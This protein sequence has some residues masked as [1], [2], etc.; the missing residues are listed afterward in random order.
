MKSE[1][2]H[3]VSLLSAPFS[4]RSMV[5]EYG[6][7]AYCL[8]PSA[9]IFVN[10]N[11]QNLYLINQCSSAA[12]KKIT[13]TSTRRFGDL[14]WD[15][16][17][18]RV[19]AVCEDHSSNGDVVN[20]IVA[21]NLTGQVETLA[22]GCDFYAYPRLSDENDSLCWI[23][24]MQPNMPWDDTQLTVAR[25][26]KDGALTGKSRLDLAEAQSIVQP[27]WHDD[28]IY[29]V[30]DVGNW[31]NI[32]RQIDGE[33]TNNAVDS[34]QSF[35]GPQPLYSMKAEF[36]TPLW[37]LGMQNYGFIAHDLILAS[38]N[39]EGSWFLLPA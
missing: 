24:W 12:P 5:H 2:N 36:A 18:N 33:D 32:Y 29:Y 22:I 14:I 39:Q 1:G 30:S 21:V 11:D 27:L 16:K 34:T 3:I 31:W 6:G 37:T 7:A 20:T 28:D 26:N 4:V 38:F 15:N 19:I 10:A 23:S 25:F 17:R 9:L 35:P 13:E 8:T